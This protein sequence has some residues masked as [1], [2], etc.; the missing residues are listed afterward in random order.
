M[1]FDTECT[2]MVLSSNLLKNI[3]K[4]KTEDTDGKLAKLTNLITIC[5]DSGHAEE[6]DDLHHVENLINSTEH[7]HENEAADKEAALAA[8]FTIYSWTE[9]IDKGRAAE[10]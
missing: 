6:D 4:L 3:T 5:P 7:E 2:T 1:L 9:V 10:N 8:G